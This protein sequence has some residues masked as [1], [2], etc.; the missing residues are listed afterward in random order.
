MTNINRRENVDITRR[1]IGQGCA[2][3]YE[4]GN[5]FLLNDSE[6]AIFVQVTFFRHFMV[7]IELLEPGIKSDEKLSPGDCGQSWHSEYAEDF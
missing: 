7:F 5:V 6:S 3:L 1:F 2:L 4:D